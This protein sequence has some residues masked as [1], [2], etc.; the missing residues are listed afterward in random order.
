MLDCPPPPWTLALGWRLLF[1]L[2]FLTF[3]SFSF[4]AWP[5]ALA[6]LALP[7]LP[8]FFE[9]VVAEGGGGGGRDA[10][11]ALALDSACSLLSSCTFNMFAITFDT[12]FSAQKWISSASACAVR[13]MRRL[14]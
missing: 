4:G 5:D 7:V 12:K 3:T 11:L 14:R 10:A 13:T 6:A 1:F 8:P 9:P 2:L